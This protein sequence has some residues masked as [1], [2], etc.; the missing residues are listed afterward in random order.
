VLQYVTA[1]IKGYTKIF[2]KKC[3]NK[4]VSRNSTFPTER[5]DLISLKS[6]NNW[7]S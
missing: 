4:I 5:S 2:V 3:A 7:K 1:N 6:T